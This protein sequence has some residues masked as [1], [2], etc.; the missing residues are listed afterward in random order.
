MNPPLKSVIEALLLAAGEPLSLA[1]L[2]ELLAPPATANEIQA[3]LAALQGDY[4]ERGLELVEV[5]SGYRLQ[6]PARFAPWIVRLAEEKPGRYSRA[7]LETLAII[8]YR[9]PVTRG[10]IEAVRGVSVNTAILRTL[11]EREWIRVI[12]HRDS[13]GRPAL[14]STTRRLLDDLQLTSLSELPTLMAPRDLADIQR[15]LELE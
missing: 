15:T 5:S 10:D 12:G 7:V 1:R 6:T 4:V 13:P 14:Y 9:Q 11:L 2:T 8:A 3:A